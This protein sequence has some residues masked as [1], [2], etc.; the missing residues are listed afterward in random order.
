MRRALIAIG[1]AAMLAPSRAWAGDVAQIDAP[2][3][4]IVP[5]TAT[6]SQILKEHEAAVG[7][8]APGTRDTR[9]EDWQFDKIGL[10]GSESLVRSG[11]DYHS[12]VTEGP[13]TE[14][15]GQLNGRR[16]H[17][18]FNGVVSPAQ[19]EDYTSFEMLIFMDV[20]GDAADPKYDVKVLG[21][22][23][24]AQPAYVL[25]V[26][27]TGA[28]HPEWLFYDRQT[29]L[30]DKAIRVVEDERATV[31]FDD[32]RATKGLKQPW[33]LHYHNGDFDFDFVRKALAIGEP[34]DPK[35]CAM[36]SSSFAFLQS[37][38]G[39]AQLPARVVLTRLPVPI[40]NHR[41][42]I[43]QSPNIVVRLFLAGRGLDFVVSAAR[44]DS[45]IDLDVAHELDLPS[46][47]QRM[48][49]GG[50]DLAYDTVIDDATL[51][52]L[53]LHKFAVHA[54]HF[55]YHVGY[56]TKIV[57]VLG[58][59]LLSSGAFKADFIK[60]SFEM[61]P[62]SFDADPL[63]DM[64]T[65]P[66]EF[67]SGYPFLHGTIDG[68]ESGDIL[69]DNDFDHT[70]IFGGYTQ[71]FPGSIK[72]VYGEQHTSTVIPFADSKSYGRDVQIW[73]GQVPNITFGPVRFANMQLIT[74][75]F[76]MDTAGRNIDAVLGGDILRFYDI[77]FDYP[78]AQ[79]LLRRNSDWLK[80]FHVANN[81]S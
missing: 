73:M 55:H 77:Y 30:I 4:G 26:R 24:G 13:L 52:G 25:E 66:I 71:R 76:P 70:F 36:P 58:Y 59:D 16:W 15:Y 31:A 32:Y 53:T 6:L 10:K 28:R 56:E 33:H 37:D 80:N 9:G 42:A 44:P 79:I 41:Y 20:L 74:A 48:Q 47:G 72:D 21:E 64:L 62:A 75:D 29:W 50:G 8:L 49:A 57:G 27:P 63:A 65:I 81:P 3:L 60:G 38:P 18:D 43:S 1:A 19:S 17:K 39:G 14:E 23:A 69:F 78:H 5:T 61:L 12:I 34:L 67:D 51:G 7:R 68:H 54:K 40:G 45:L 11:S 22:V 35:Q 2:P 46:F